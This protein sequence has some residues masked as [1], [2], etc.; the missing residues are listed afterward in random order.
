MSGI[1]SLITG[2]EQFKHRVI[3]RN[4]GEG[5]ERRTGANRKEP[6][7]SQLIPIQI[8]PQNFQFFAVGER[9]QSKRFTPTSFPQPYL[10]GHT[11]I[12]SPLGFASRA[13]NESLAV[14]IEDV[15][16]CG[17]DA[18]CLPTLD[19]KQVVVR[20]PDAPSH[21]HTKQAIDPA[22]NKAWLK[23]VWA[24]IVHESSSTAIQDGVAIVLFSPSVRGRA[25]EGGRGSLAHHL[26]S[27]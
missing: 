17:V 16:R 21:E 15:H 4:S 6:L 26:Q 18:S 13:N 14:A 23:K 27:E 3:R 10:P 11:S 25:A 22:C 12:P 24:R 20:K 5:F 1:C 2:R 7:H 9:P 19:F 8:F